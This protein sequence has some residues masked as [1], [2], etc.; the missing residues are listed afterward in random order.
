MSQERVRTWLVTGASRG[1]G[2]VVV[3]AVLEA[4]ERVVATSRTPGSLSDLEEVHGDRLVPLTLDVTDRSAVLDAFASAAEATGGVD[5]LVNNAGY[6]LAGAVEEVGEQLVRDQFDVNFLGAL[7]AVQGVLPIMRRQG[8][9]NIFQIS[10]IAAV[11]T[12]PNLGIYC[13]SKWALEA[14]SETLAQEVAGHG[15]RVT[16]VQLGELRTA[17]SADSMVRAEP[18]SAY[19][20]VLASRRHGLSGAFADRQPGSPRRAAQV[21]LDVVDR[22][23]LPLRL[24]LGTG[25]AALAP[26]VYRNRLD[27]W[28]RWSALAPVV[29]LADEDAAAP[30]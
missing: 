16:I 30:S 13:A 21:L 20:D 24:L 2:R 6:G 18:M 4:G 15:I 25:A 27:E 28:Q 1:L 26:Q 11:A 7:W 29:D 22:D 8:Q 17:W 12:Y 9:G 5:V 3:E 14:M 23:D 19:D 10:S